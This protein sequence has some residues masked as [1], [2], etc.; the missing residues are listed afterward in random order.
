M[1]VLEYSP[2]ADGITPET[3]IYRYLSTE[4]F[5]RLLESGVS[6]TRMST[7]P[8]RLE[9]GDFSFT[10][11]AEKL[12]DYRK[13]N[14]FFASCWTLQAENP[15]V[16]NSEHSFVL[17]QR[18]L[19]NDGSANMWE[20]YCAGGGVRIC[21][22]INRL[23]RALAGALGSTGCLFKGAVTYCARD[24]PVRIRDKA[25]LEE[26]MFYKRVG[27]RHEA[28]YRYV[29]YRQGQQKDYLVIAVGSLFEFLDEILVFP[30]KNDKF[31]AIANDLHGKGVHI[32]SY[33]HAAGTNIKNGKPFCR[34]SQL[35]GLASQTIG[36]VRFL[37]SS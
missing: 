12:H 8:D 30:L 3:K 29:A 15:K 20:S 11:N 18:E 13:K 9:A 28:E 24:D 26:T 14:D 21:T 22:T 23:D 19:T 17:A 2:G 5:D 31:D 4:A 1:E 34:V 7:W 33:P 6:L 27:Y 10:A 32:A 25:Q 36:E 37:K 16:F 35:Y